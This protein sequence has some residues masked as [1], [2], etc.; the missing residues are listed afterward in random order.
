[1][2]PRYPIGCRPE[3]AAAGGEGRGAIG[4]RSTQMVTRK[5]DR[6]RSRRRGAARRPQR[7]LVTA[8]ERIFELRIDS[9][10]AGG[11]GV[12]RDSDGRVVFVPF[13]AP[14]DRVRVRTVGSH[15]RYVNAWV[16]ELLEA[17][18]MRTDPACVVFGS[19]GG[20]A[21]QHIDYAAQLDAKA[22]IV[23]DAFARIG[24]F[25]L[26]A[27]LEVTPSPAPYAYR[28]RARVF[29]E[30]GRVGFRRRRS[31]AIC[32]TD[33]CPI[34]VSPLQSELAEL[35]RNPPE[36]DGEWELIRGDDSSRACPLPAGDEHPITYRV[37]G[38][39]I[40]V[41]A[42]VF[43]QSN[44]ALLGEL[45]RVVCSIAGEGALALD[46]FAGAG[47]FSVGLARRF[48]R[49]VAV[50]SNARAAS[51]LKANLRSNGCAGVTVIADRLED[52]LE[53]RRLDGLCPDAVVLDPPRTGLPPGTADALAE[54]GP[55]R[56]VYLGCDPATQARD[57][58]YLAGNGFALVRVQAFD[59]FPQTPHVE[60]L[61]V[62]ESGNQGSTSPWRTA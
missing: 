55:G 41:S 3:I 59:L 31:H 38:A 44:S 19:C 5:R 40:T 15:R 14:G 39:D 42:G 35:A 16:E 47:F 26:P 29:V 57:S 53:H 37:D 27:N 36:Q 2:E 43:A 58:R 30:E 11:D 62:F 60:S 18:P 52:V 24:G 50:E 7:G 32:A 6:K 4:T 48:E 9:L 33:H 23:R 17:S 45:S 49:V 22:K 1:M 61:A 21:W 8:E 28:S 56:I 46:L 34:L 13:T 12:G 10:A 20:C 54:L 51:D 25:P